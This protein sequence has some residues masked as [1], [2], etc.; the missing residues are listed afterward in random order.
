MRKQPKNK[1]DISKTVRNL[2]IAP[3]GDR[4]AARPK[5]WLS[6]VGNRG[7]RLTIRGQWSHARCPGAKVDRR[8][9]GTHSI[10][11]YSGARGYEKGIH[12]LPEHACVILRPANGSGLL[13]ELW[14]P[15]EDI[16]LLR[17]S[18][19]QGGHNI[20]E[21]NVEEESIQSP[22]NRGYGA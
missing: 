3:V 21:L 19:N 9:G 2:G 13:N 20:I 5:S 18:R 8:T 14:H 4:E 10:P 6:E 17:R 22:F 1:T 16:S 12:N 7:P 11:E 15:P